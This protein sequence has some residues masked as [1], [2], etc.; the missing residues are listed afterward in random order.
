MTG[1]EGMCDIRFFRRA[2]LDYRAAVNLLNVPENDEAYM[3]AV[4][5]HSTGCGEDFESISGMCRCDGSQY[6]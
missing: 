6:A 3:N 5:Y 4:A 2:Y 1:R